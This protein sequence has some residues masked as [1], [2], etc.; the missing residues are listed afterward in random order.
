LEVFSSM[1][2]AIPALKKIR[3]DILNNRVR[4]E[5]NGWIG[6]SQAGG[7]QSNST[8]KK[9]WSSIEAKGLQDSTFEEILLLR[10]HSGKPK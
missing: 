4:I 10:L 6:R 8:I 1:A 5:K 2:D 7:S 9:R 3:P